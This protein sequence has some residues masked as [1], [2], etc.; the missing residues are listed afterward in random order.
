MAQPNIYYDTL[1]PD[2]VSG[3]LAPVISELNLE[4]NCR[5]LAMEGWTV[6]ENVA[7]DDFNARF[8]KK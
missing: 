4:E 8:R 3:D 2:T 5:Q 6:V 1:S 7:A